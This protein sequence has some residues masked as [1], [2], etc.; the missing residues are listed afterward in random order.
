ELEDRMATIS[1]ERAQFVDLIEV[2][3]RHHARRALLGKLR[4][5]R[6]LGRG[7][8]PLVFPGEESAREREVRQDAEAV[9]NAGRDDVVQRLPV[10]QVEVVL[11]AHEPGEALT[12][13]R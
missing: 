11:R 3:V 10:Q 2:P 5:P 12:L 6:A 4:Q 1:C 13:R 8:A 7:R 9:P